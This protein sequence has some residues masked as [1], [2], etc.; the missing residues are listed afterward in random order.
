MK[1]EIKKNFKSVKQKKKGSFIH[2]QENVEQ[3]KKCINKIMW[4]SWKNAA[5]NSLLAQ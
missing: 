3:K 5:T 1:T 2:L 4:R